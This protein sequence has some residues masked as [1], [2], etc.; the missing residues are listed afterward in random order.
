ME[1][2]ATLK[3]EVV[4]TSETLLRIYHV[5]RLDISNDRNFYDVF[6]LY[7]FHLKCCYAGDRHSGTS[8]L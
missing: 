6:P 4:D 3:M 8:V 2:L 5:T 7:P 1:G